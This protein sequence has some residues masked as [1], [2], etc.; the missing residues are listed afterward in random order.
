MFPKRTVRLT[1]QTSAHLRFQENHVK[2]SV[3][4]AVLATIVCA[5]ASTVLAAPMGT[6]PRP[7][8]GGNTSS[9]VVVT[10]ILVALG[11]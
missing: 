2:K 5:T 8:T 6:N 10:A 7:N 11:L 3:R 9:S 4:I 1:L